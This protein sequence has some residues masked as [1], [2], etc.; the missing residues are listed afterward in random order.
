MKVMI[1]GANGFVGRNLVKKLSENNEIIA[2]VRDKLRIC[3]ELKNDNVKVVECNMNDYKQLIEQLKEFGTIDI[4][5]HLAWNSANGVN[6][7]NYEV[8]LENIKNSCDLIKVAAELGIKRFLYAGTIAEYEYMNT[9]NHNFHNA[10]LNSIYNISKMSARYML[11]TLAS[12][13]DIEFIPITISNIYGVGELSERFFITVL[14]KM[15]KNE[16]INVT[17]A[18]QAHDFIYIDDA[19]KMIALVGEKGKSNKNYYIG[20]R[21]TRVLKEFIEE[22]KSISGSNSKINYG[23]VE[24]RYVPID[25]SEFDMN[26]IYNEFGFEA[27]VPFSKGVNLVLEEIRNAEF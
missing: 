6:K 5:Y 25:F 24:Y 17:L 22:M 19:V 18:T 27:E 20:N 12:N 4:I 23:A 1:T 2:I 16:D 26:T 21:T 14:K 13:Y 15:I 9:I 7:S 3:S 8:Q 11:M 10:S